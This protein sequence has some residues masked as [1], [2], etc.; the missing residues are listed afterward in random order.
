MH[1]KVCDL[2]KLG[3]PSD[4]TGRNSGMSGGRAGTRST[5]EQNPIQSVASTWQMVR[6]HFAR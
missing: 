5:A 6:F 4:S 3:K 2:Q 1:H